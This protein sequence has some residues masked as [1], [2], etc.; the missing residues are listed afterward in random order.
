MFERFL[1]FAL[2]LSAAVAMPARGHSDIGW[3]R[4]ETANFEFVGNAPEASIRIVADR[5]ER[6]RYALGSV[7]P[8]PK[9]TRK[10]RVIVFRDSASFRSFK[11]LRPDGTADDSVVGLFV[12]GED[13]NSIAIASDNVTPC[14]FCALPFADRATDRIRRRASRAPARREDVE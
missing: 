12:A 5:L 8:L 9:S 7:L 14:G 10:T 2:L 11:P 4:T 3:T 13:L 1:I 6:F